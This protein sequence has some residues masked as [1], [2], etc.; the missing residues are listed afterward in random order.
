MYYSCVTTGHTHR[1]VHELNIVTSVGSQGSD[2]G[3]NCPQQVWAAKFQ[4]MAQTAY[5]NCG[6]PRFRNGTNCPHPIV[7]PKFLFL[8]NKM[9]T[10]KAQLE[11]LH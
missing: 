5:N 8:L 9:K 7:D 2:D 1:I 6:Q 10:V 3:T 11:Q 4:K